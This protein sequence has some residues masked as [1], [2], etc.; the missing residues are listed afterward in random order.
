M[1]KF[2]IWLLASRPKT[3]LAAFVPV[4]VGASLAYHEQQI[5][6]QATLAALI[7]SILIQIGTNFTNDLFDFIKGAD[8]SERIGPIRVLNAGLVS[9]EQMKLAIWL[10]F[11]SAF[12]IGL[13]LV[14]LGGPII[15]IIG[16]LSIIA[17]I[18][19]TAGPFPL[20]YNG[21]GDVFSFVF[22]GIV[23]TVGTY[24]VN[25]GEFSIEALL[26]SLPVGALVTAI[27]VVNNY[28]DVDQDQIAGKRTLAV[29]FGKQFARFEYLLL[30]T[31]AYVIPLLLVLNYN[32]DGWLLLPYLTLPVAVRLIKMLFI[33][34]GVQL[35]KTLELTAKFSALYGLLL[36]IGFIL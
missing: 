28:R 32:L 9:E 20:A 21:L 13:Y 8:N 5:H 19:Y 15:L 31:I 33:N 26:A 7:C 30:L 29:I 12:L 18:A 2:R 6:Y 4:T 22:F 36:S 14:Y 34:S 27:L 17:G 3:L 11:G 1:T 24:Y 25:T 10:T 35:N 23:G 16:I